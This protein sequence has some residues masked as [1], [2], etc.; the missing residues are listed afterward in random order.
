MACLL[1]SRIYKRADFDKI[2]KEGFTYQL[3]TETIDIIKQIATN[4]GAPEYIKTPHFEKRTGNGMGYANKPRIQIKDIS[5]ADWNALRNFKATTLEKKEGIA[6]S[7]D[8]IRKHLNKMTDKTYD[9]L[10]EQI[11]QEIDLINPDN[12]ENEDVCN[13]LKQIGDAIFDI[14]SSNKF[15]SKMYA[16]LYKDLMNKYDFMKAI[17]KTNINTDVYI[18][19]DFAYCSP[20]KDYDAFCK[21]NKTNEKRRALG[22]FYINLM[23]HDV[24]PATKIVSMIDEIQEE[25][26]SFIKK[27]DHVNIVDEMSE[28]VYILIVNGRSMLKTIDDEWSQMLNRIEI[29]SSMQNKSYPS[30]SNKT[31]FKHMD[32]L[33]AIKK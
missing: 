1:S 19:K 32:M 10:Y 30:I 20:D 4:V 15:Y 8:K 23:L 28:L 12:L 31:I 26:L 24:V 16:K 9:K 18:F 25:L 13:E 33:E 17:F 14:A 7:I 5:D 29:V 2:K 27:E 6:L 11:I 21:N 22:A 3:P